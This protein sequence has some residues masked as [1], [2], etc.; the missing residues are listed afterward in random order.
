MK[1]KIN[2]LTKKEI[3]IGDLRVWWYENLGPSPQIMYVQSP[4]RALEV[5]SVLADWHLQREDI[6]SNVFGLEIFEWGE[7]EGGYDCL[8]WQEW[9]EADTGR[10]INDIRLGKRE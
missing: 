6:K 3:K 9:Y 4:E 8:H 5:I 2:P 10:S 1:K 7:D